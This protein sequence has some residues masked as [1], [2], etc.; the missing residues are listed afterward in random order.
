MLRFQFTVEEQEKG[1]PHRFIVAIHGNPFPRFREHPQFFFSYTKLCI[2][3]KENN[4]IM[5][6]VRVQKA[7]SRKVGKIFHSDDQKGREVL[8]SE[9]FVIEYYKRGF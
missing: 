7:K 6:K 8:D 1:N 9:R 2:I 5:R 3:H 4:Q